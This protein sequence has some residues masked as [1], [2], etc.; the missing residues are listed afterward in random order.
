MKKLSHRMAWTVVA[1]SLRLGAADS[2]DSKGARPLEA[3][4][5]AITARDA[6]LAFTAY[7]QAF[8]ASTNGAGYYK[9]TDTGG[10]NHFWTQ[11][12]EIEMVLDVWERSHSA[13]SKRLIK[14]SIAG[15]LD[16]FGTDWLSNKYNDDILWMVIACARAYRAIGTESYKDLALYHFDK[17]YARAW[18]GDLGGGLW[19]S[20]D[21]GSKN[22]CVNG[23]G[24]IAACLLYQITRN[25]G[26]LEKAQATYA[27]DRDNL[28]DESTGAVRDHR[29][30][31]GRVGGQ[32]FTYNEGTFIGAANLLAG[33]TGK[34]SYLADA[35]KAADYTRDHLCA[36]GVLPG[37]D[38]GDAAGF[39]GIFIRWLARYAND[40][41][42]W[43]RYQHW[44]LHNAAA[45]WGHRRTDNLVWNR[46]QWQTPAGP[47]R[48][49]ACAD[50][51]IILNVVS[52][53]HLSDTR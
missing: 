45:A 29:R 30:R 49:W 14:E 9:E 19:W 44:T 6:D 35:Q 43:G 16:H 2:A 48:A 18:S 26:Y 39:N 3:P 24:A 31:D 4:H 53:D 42:V 25:P 41:H 8:Y 51:V 10:R 20:T 28:F 50:A 11:A 1:W 37:Y 52:R 47:L 12:E 7:Q 27:W 33:L 40:H 15:F 17:T 22:A 13:E 23:P 46:W 36:N 32:S 34:A 38:G 5:P 21:N